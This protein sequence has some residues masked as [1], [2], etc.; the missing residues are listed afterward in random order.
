MTPQELRHLMCGK[1]DIRE[2][3]GVLLLR[4]PFGLDFGD[5]LVIRVRPKGSGFQVDDNGETWLSLLMNGTA[6]DPDRVQDV[7]G[8]VDLDQEDG[9]LL[10]CVPTTSELADAIFRVTSA[11]IR[12]HATFR[13]RGRAEPSDL[14]E[15]VVSLLTEVAQEE[16]VILRLDEIVDETGVLAADAILGEE[17]PLIVIAA[18][19]VE[20]LMEAELVFLR[21]QMLQRRGYVL[22]VVS[23]SQ[24][25][26]RKHFSRANYYT[27]KTLEFDDWTGAF[28]DFAHRRLAELH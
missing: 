9:T 26:G 14:K 22:A 12:V 16:G 6:P 24:A 25:I 8:A 15:R 11:S 20:R 4:T 18:S 23:S 3:D 27:D 5:D 19:S 21:R 28:R 13:P 7:K 2:E 1:F 17:A 10:V